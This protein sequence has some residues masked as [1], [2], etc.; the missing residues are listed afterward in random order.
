MA[1]EVEEPAGGEENNLVSDAMALFQD[2]E[3]QG[4]VEAE[5]QLE[6]LT[7]WEKNIASVLQPASIPP[8]SC[9]SLPGDHT[10]A[11]ASTN[12]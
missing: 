9:T 12:T 10:C 2:Q 11:G 8:T 3:E 5:S 1:G 4:Y 7:I 6:A